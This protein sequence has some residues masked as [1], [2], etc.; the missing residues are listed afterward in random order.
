[1]EAPRRRNSRPGLT[2]MADRELAQQPAAHPEHYLLQ[3]VLNLC[4]R[5][6]REVSGS[7]RG[8]EFCGVCVGFV[9]RGRVC[10]G[11]TDNI[12]RQG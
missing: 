9:V 10:S 4:R 5:N 7:E 11:Y 12:C 3:S 6:F 1:M 8:G 2:A